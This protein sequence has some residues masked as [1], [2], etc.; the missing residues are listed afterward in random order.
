MATD[1]LAMT[2]KDGIEQSLPINVELAVPASTTTGDPVL[3]NDMVCYAQTTRDDD[4]NAT[5]T[6]PCAF[7]REL[8]VYG[9][10]DGTNSAVAVGDKLYFDATDDQI[11]KDSSNGVAFG[12]AL[13]TVTSGSSATIM[14]GFGL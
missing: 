11:N 10:G 4:G 7:A 1:Y 13:G 12:Y 9:R 3:L 6:I 5:V 2:K 8:T 14:V